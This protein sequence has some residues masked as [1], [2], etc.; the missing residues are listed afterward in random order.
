MQYISLLLA[1][2]AKKSTFS[3]NYN[4]KNTL[5]G[6]ELACSVSFSFLN[7]KLETLM[8]VHGLYNQH[9]VHTQNT[10]KEEQSAWCQND[11]GSCSHEQRKGLQYL[12]AAETIGGFFAF[13]HRANVMEFSSAVWDGFVNLCWVVGQR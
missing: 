3:L 4:E 13:C 5:K 6:L 12:H 10:K 7:L 8:S 2:G 11:K 1:F 9:A